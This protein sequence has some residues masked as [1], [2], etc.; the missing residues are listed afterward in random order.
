MGL[1]LIMDAG[2]FLT[3]IYVNHRTHLTKFVQ[4]LQTVQTKYSGAE[5]DN[6]PTLLFNYIH[7]HLNCCGIHSYTEWFNSTINWKRE[8]T[9]NNVTYNTFCLRVQTRDKTT[10][11]TRF[12]QISLDLLYVN[13]KLHDKSNMVSGWRKCTSGKHRGCGELLLQHTLFSTTNI[14]ERLYTLLYFV[15]HVLTICVYVIKKD[16]T[17]QKGKNL[18]LYHEGGFCESEKPINGITTITFNTDNKAEMDPFAPTGISAYT[19]E[20][21]QPHKINKQ[22]FLNHEYKTHK[23]ALLFQLPDMVHFNE[24]DGLQENEN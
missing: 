10:T 3:L 14:P 12:S 23:Y 2:V 18:F 19:N 20:H 13:D 21:M 7:Q 4:E 8:V 17:E 6:F 16:L 9:Y 5:T 11:Q 22:L 24:L 15:A 1:L